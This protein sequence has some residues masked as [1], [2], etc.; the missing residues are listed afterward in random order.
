MVDWA[1]YGPKGFEHGKLERFPEGLP[2]VPTRV[3]ELRVDQKLT[4]VNS[5]YTVIPGL[6]R[7]KRFQKQAGMLSGEFVASPIY[8][9]VYS[10]QYCIVQN[11]KN[12]YYGGLNTE[13]VQN[14]PGNEVIRDPPGHD[15]VLVPQK[16]NLM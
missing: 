15:V 8:S 14:S 5:R 7:R 10:L 1:C 12:I 4:I 11:D 13:R 3:G 9:S 16:H 6:T 2:S